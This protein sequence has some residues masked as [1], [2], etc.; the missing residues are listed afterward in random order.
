M[1]A[2]VIPAGGGGMAAGGCFY[3]ENK[4]VKIVGCQHQ[5]SP[6]LALSLKTGKA[7][8]ELPLLKRLQEVLK[9]ELDPS[10]S[11]TSCQE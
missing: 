11:T 1:K 10:A 8:T 7:V 9:G 4:K 3:L 6:A 5:N 2:L